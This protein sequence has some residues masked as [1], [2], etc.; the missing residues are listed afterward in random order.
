MAT[1]RLARK[2]IASSGT[3]TAA[4][5]VATKLKRA[6]QRWATVALHG[7]SCSVVTIPD[8]HPFLRLPVL[9]M[10]LDG[11]RSCRHHPKRCEVQVNP[12]FAP[13]RTLAASNA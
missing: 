1:A 3:S 7:V 6:S 9:P 10:S 8:Y 11:Q 13:T 2:P 12:R 5:A 4:A